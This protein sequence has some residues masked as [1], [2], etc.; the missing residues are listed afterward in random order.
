[1]TEIIELLKKAET[2]RQE[3][4]KQLPTSLG[5]FL[6]DHVIE[7]HDDDGTMPWFSSRVKLVGK[8]AH[9]Q[10]AN[11]ELNAALQKLNSKLK[12]YT[13]VRHFRC[14]AWFAETEPGLIAS[15]RKMS[16]EQKWEH[17][18]V[19]RLAASGHVES[20]LRYRRC[21]QCRRWFYATKSYGKFCAT[22]CRRKFESTSDE[23]KL[24]RRRYMAKWRRDDRE[25]E[26]RELAKA[27]IGGR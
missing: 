12:R 21:D 22:P 2:L 11:D 16:D 19:V 1:V 9:L 17:R 27:K 6:E 8:M 26:E 15:T 23:F 24:K 20:I 4:R 10:S 14:R 25:R 18:L 13:F 3:I 7:P 5:F